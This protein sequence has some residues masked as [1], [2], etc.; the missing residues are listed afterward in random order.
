ME[1]IL[2]MM[3]RITVSDAIPKAGV[4][5]KILGFCKCGLEDHIRVDCPPSTVKSKE[6]QKS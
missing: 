6:T 2:N 3:E 4:E 1:D 5:G